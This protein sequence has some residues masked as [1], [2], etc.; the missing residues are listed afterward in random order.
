MK[1]SLNNR[2][3]GKRLVEGDE[4]DIN[5]YEMLLKEEND[6]I[7]VKG[8]DESGN[9]K[10]LS[11]GNS[12]GSGI[13]NVWYYTSGSISGVSG[14]AVIATKTES[15][16]LLDFFTTGFNEVKPENMTTPGI[17]FKKIFAGEVI[18]EIVAT[19]TNGKITSSTISV[20][21]NCK[22]LYW[23]LAI[24]QGVLIT[25][26]AEMDGKQLI[27]ASTYNEILTNIYD[28][29]SNTLLYYA[30]ASDSSPVYMTITPESL[31]KDMNIILFLNDS[32]AQEPYLNGKP[33]YD[34]KWDSRVKRIFNT[35]DN[36]AFTSYTPS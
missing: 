22:G 5:A 12:E 35:S 32:G 8:R 17:F 15:V 27:K 34:G 30:T 21:S 18:G 31:V 3:K 26:Q 4:N 33:L 11:G 1:R 24:T 19:V 23:G 7:V 10:V 13:P 14:N 20:D 16:S 25:N 2:F 6:K 9:V 29:I 36:N 28:S